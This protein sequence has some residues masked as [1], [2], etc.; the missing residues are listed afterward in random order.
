MVYV[1][2][3]FQME[4]IHVQ[5]YKV[6]QRHSHRWCHMW[7][8]T[9][10]ELMAMA[11]K[12]GLKRQWLQCGKHFTHFDLVPTKRVLAIANGAIEYSMRK[13]IGDNQK[14]FHEMEKA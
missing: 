11:S 2:E 6:G 13:W 7:A 1:D 12:I 14:R 4:S 10:A 8:D 5:A 9:G 3:T